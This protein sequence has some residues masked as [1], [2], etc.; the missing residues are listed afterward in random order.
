MRA[1]N[2]RVLKIFYKKRPEKQEEDLT[3]RKLGKIE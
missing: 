3:E 1:L 2:K